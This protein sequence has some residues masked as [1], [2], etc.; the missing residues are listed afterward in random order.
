MS[1]KN[2]SD[3]IGNRTRDVPA[4]NAVPHKIWEPQPPGTLKACLR[5]VMGLLY[6]TP[7]LCSYV[8]KL[9]L[10]VQLFLSESCVCPLKDGAQTALFKDQVRTAL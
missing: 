4:C 5:P 10:S 6:L 3:T 1:M 8:L 2:S 9:V 7:S